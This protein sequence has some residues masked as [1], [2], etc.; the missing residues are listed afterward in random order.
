[1]SK[2]SFKKD[3]FF[4]SIFF[5]VLCI[6]GYIYSF[7]LLQENFILPKEFVGHYGIESVW[8]S[9]HHTPFLDK[10]MPFITLY[11]EWYGYIMVVIIF[12]LFKKYPNILILALAGLFSTIVSNLLK[13]YFFQ[14]RPF[15]YFAANGMEK[16][17]TPVDGIPFLN[18]QNSFPSGH[19]L[20]AFALTTVVGLAFRGNKF[21]VLISILVASLVGISRMY[22]IQHFLQDVIFGAYLGLIVGL[23]AQVLGEFLIDKF[24]K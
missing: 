4:F 3:W 5:V 22:L 24:S 15:P 13:L 9:S 8:F 14:P 2:F 7:I 18:G 19:T 20:G 12:L 11:G 23:I 16:L 21:I 17:I 1:L 6:A 10:F